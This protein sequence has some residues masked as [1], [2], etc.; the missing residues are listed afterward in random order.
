MSG[1]FLSPDW[2]RVAPLKLRRRA[3]VQ[4]ARHVYRG[5]PWFILQD[6]QAGKFHR[7]SPQ[8]YAIF[9]RMDGQKTIQELWELGCKLYPED[10]P[11]QTELLQL[12]SQLHNSDLVTGDKRPNLREIDR[13][14]REEKR[15]TIIGYFKNPLSVRIPLFDPEPIL[16]FL[17][18]LANYIFS[19]FGAILWCILIF[20][21]LATTFMSW[22]RLEVPGAEAILTGA[23]IAYLAIAY[24]F[25]KFLHEL[26]HGLAIKRWGG[27]VREVGVMMLIFFPVPYVDA[28]QSSFFPYK[29]QRI[30]VSAAGI[31]V[32]LAVAAMALIVWSFA[33]QGIVATLAY[34]LFLI[35]GVSTLFFNGNPLLRFDGYFVFADFLEIPNL[36]QR[37][38]QYFWYFVQKY[39]LG[40]G[41]ARIPIVGPGEEIWL[42]GYAVAAFLY[43]MFVMIV[44]SLYVATALPIVGVAIVIWSLYTVFLVPVG[45]G[46]RF[47]LTEPSLEI[48]RA[49]I[50]MRVFSLI[51]VLFVLMFFIPVPHTTVSDAVLE[52]P[53]ESAIRAQGQGFV[54]D[55]LVQNGERINVGDPILKLSEPLLGVEKEVAIAEVEDARLRVEMIP[56]EDTNARSLWT[57]QLGFYQARLNDLDRRADELWVRSPTDGIII[58]PNQYQL[59]GRLVQQGEI[60]GHV[61][62]KS[63]LLWRTAVPADRAEFIDG[64]LLSVSMRLKSDFN[65]EYDAQITSRSPEITTR[66]DSFALT[67]RAGG[68]LVVDPSQESPTSIIPVAT[69]VLSTG[70]ALSDMPLLA[71]GSRA[72]VRF[73]HRPAPIAPRVWRAVRQTFLAYFGT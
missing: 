12:L 65:V 10:P 1:A 2:Y 6:L 38:N 26:G 56:L 44:I 43:R 5:K 41:D 64:D 46:A 71:I 42:F 33:E 37:S 16:K 18:P 15:K 48:Q 23:N 24:I 3:H 60:V 45:K 14:A 57:E 9:A 21:A 4:I 36:G 7:L 20:A 63:E 30:L 54:S 35:G 69:Y 67:N 55:V 68:P 25:V 58:L 39:V 73:E 32:E 34:N 49:K 47:L 53:G 50:F 61:Q 62:K 11:S 19:P 52:T 72:T 13:R 51:F 31:L 40:H 28:S 22:D 17:T 29:Y 59:I 27:E 70:T 66:L 8:S